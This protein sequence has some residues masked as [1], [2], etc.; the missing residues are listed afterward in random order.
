MDRL[1]R[2]E[3]S[4]LTRSKAINAL[5]YSPEMDRGVWRKT[6]HGATVLQDS[7]M[8]RN[9]I[10]LVLNTKVVAVE[11]RKLTL[12]TAEGNTKVIGFSAC[13]WATGVAINPLAKKIQERLP[14]QSN[15]RQAAC[16][17]LI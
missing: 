11:E 15:F 5:L 3:E 16:R 2:L 4:A 7:C 1:L 9:G 14:A 17:D 6:T 10:D 8:C 12:T 13:V